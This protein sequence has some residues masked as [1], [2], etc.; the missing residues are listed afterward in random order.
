MSNK[1]LKAYLILTLV[2]L[3]WGIASPV[4]KYT[5]NFITP[6]S[7]L[8]WRF[9]ITSIIFLPFF[10]YFI[11]KHPI[12]LKDLP[13]L[14]FLGFLGTPLTLI[15][16]FEGY[17]KTSSMDGV[18]ISATAPIF[19]TIGGVLFLKEKVTL[20]ERIGLTI[21]LA[22][23]LI[24]VSQPLLE[25]GLLRSTNLIGNLL[26]FGSVISW[27][28]FTLMSKHE[29]KKH[30]PFVVTA[31]SFF[32]GLIIMVPFFLSERFAF[33]DWQ[34]SAFLTPSPI[35]QMPDK[36]LGGILYMAIFSSVIA[37]TLYEYGLSII[38]AS[39]ATLFAYL[40][41]I[42][43]APVAL[44]WL[45]EKITPPFIIGAVVIG[46]GVAISEY[47]TKEEIKS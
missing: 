13:S 29:F 2:S 44:L 9:L 18:L 33:I 22:G 40:Q 24:T 25:G 3:I 43:A 19:I 36:A 8:F 28:V 14:T 12:K 45:K 42:F 41:P 37:Y 26:V 7:F 11:R 15:L 17:T 16:I 21:A 4:I 32:V 35:I 5:L 27:A 20:I 47:R 23:S 46:L 34:K 1:R 6:Y 30:H 38:E 10:V 39:E 31:L